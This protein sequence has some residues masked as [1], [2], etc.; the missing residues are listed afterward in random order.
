MPDFM[1]NSPRDSISAGDSR[2]SLK[3]SL[4]SNSKRLRKQTFLKCFQCLLSL[5][6]Y[7]LKSCMNL[8]MILAN[9][10]VQIPLI[11]FRSL[12][13][14]IDLAIAERTLIVLECYFRVEKISDNYTV[15]LFS[16]SLLCFYEKKFCAIAAS[17]KNHWDCL[18]W[19]I[20]GGG[21]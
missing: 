10:L 14:R 18:R 9:S 3:I 4:A 6:C 1:T 8:N 19:I 7:S 15:G 17:L 11:H 12:V 20:N 16:S 5:F 21:V 13:V 2:K